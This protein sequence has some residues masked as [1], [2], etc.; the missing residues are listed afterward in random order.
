MLALISTT[1]ETARRLE[2]LLAPLGYSV[3]PGDLTTAERDRAA[4]VIVDWD[5]LG[6]EGCRALCASTHAAVVV[7]SEDPTPAT[8]EAAFAAGAVD[9]LRLPGDEPRLIARARAVGH[10]AGR[11]AADLRRRDDDE[12]LRTSEE[13]FFKIFHASPACITITRMSDDRF[14]D[15]ND[16]FLVATGFSREEVIGRTGV[17]LGLWQQP[18]VR[19]RLAAAIRAGEKVRDVAVR[20]V[21]K[22]GQPLDF[23]M[24]LE[25][26]SAGGDE[27]VIALGHDVTERKQLEELLRQSQKMDAIGRLAGGVAHDFNNLLTVIRGYADMLIA[28]P[29]TEPMA[30]KA[31]LQIRRS[32][33]RAASL[34]GQLLAFTRRQPHQPRV[35]L[36]NKVVLSMGALLRRIIGEDIEL[37]LRLSP[38]VGLVRVDPTQMEQV[39]LNLAINARDAM[40]NGGRLVVE[41]ANAVEAG[42]QRL[43]LT[44]RDSGHGMTEETRLRVFEPFFTTKD[45]DKGTGLGLSIVY[46][47]VVQNGGSITV[48]SSPETGT[49]FHILLPRVADAL[50]DEPAV[51]TPKVTP[52]AGQETILLVEDDEDV[53][54]FVQLVLSRSGYRVLT[55]EDGVSAIEVARAQADDIHLLLSDVV[56]PHMNGIHLASEIRPLRPTMKVLHMSGYPGDSIA[57]HGQ[58]PLGDAFLQ[59]PF[60]ASALI[61]TVRAV[62]D[63][64]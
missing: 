52:R 1:D 56:M 40:A 50:D 21:R 20:L 53:R 62:L 26:F 43:R 39:L 44:V 37:E 42:E 45:V 61:E 29:A 28:Q 64:R 22:S 47:V 59:K 25:A 11:A 3:V 58:V 12:A 46:G 49:A 5:R 10:G 23:L 7:L 60:S 13:R 30:R 55:A 17:E 14:V 33:L 35:I 24:S 27:C 32:S 6:C 38:E 51:R 9:L 57:R 8:L 34:T 41:T 15:A 16:R 18:Q 4:L 63:G 19:S 36:L 2:A 48:E 31:A 54:D